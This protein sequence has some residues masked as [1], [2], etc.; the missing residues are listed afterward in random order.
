MRQKQSTKILFINYGGYFLTANTFIPDNSLAGLAGVFSKHDIP[1][2]IIDFQNPHDMGTIMEYSKTGFS[3]ELA[4]IIEEKKVP[5]LSLIRSYQQSRFQAEEKF[6]KEK[7]RLL[8]DKIERENVSVVGFKLWIGNGI[9][10]AM[11]MAGEIR[12]NFPHIKLIAGGPAIQ[13]LGSDFQH[14]SKIFDHIVAGDGEEAMTSLIKGH[15]DNNKQ[16]HLKERCENIDQF[17]FPLYDRK[18]YPNIDSFFK[19][20]ILDDSRGCFNKCAFCSHGFINGRGVRKRL[21]ASVVDE[22][23][24]IKINDGISYFRFSGS[25]PPWKFIVEIAKK[26]IERKLDVRYSIFSSMNNCNPKDLPLLKKSGLRSIFFGLE[27]GDNDFLKNVHNKSNVNSDHIINVCE[28]A[29]KEQIFAALSFIVPL[30][31]ETSETKKKSL[32][33]AKRIFKNHSLGSI[34]VLPPMLSP[35]SE[36]WM[37]MDQFG[38]EL[39]NGMSKTDYKL[40]ILEKNYDFLLPRE[41]MEDMGYSLNGKSMHQILNECEEFIQELGRENIITNFDDS[42]Y[43]LSLMSGTSPEKFKSEMIKNL[44]LGGSDNLTNLISKFNESSSMICQ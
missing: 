44:I 11:T 23:E 2:E 17:P 5:P 21:P 16:Y 8:M 33:L 3:H 40:N 29:M 26:I 32:D 36:W 38:F 10:N 13:Y 18:I 9:K 4:R 37:N 22:M 41:S 27:S 25:N 7:T 1:V 35:G 39:E 31:F 19:I 30:P 24:R 34:M 6:T 43:M 14:Y 28:S 12:K 42:A 20:R 15:L